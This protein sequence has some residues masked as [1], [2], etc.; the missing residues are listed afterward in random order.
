MRKFT[1]S[2][3]SVI[4]N[5]VVFIFLFNLSVGMIN[6]GG[7]F[8]SYMDPDVFP[9]LDS[10]LC[11]TAP[12]DGFGGEWKNVN[13]AG[14][15]CYL[16]GKQM[17]VSD[18]LIADANQLVDD[19][20]KLFQTQ[21]DPT[22][23]QTVANFAGSFGNWIGMAQDAFR[24]FFTS[25]TYPTQFLLSLWPCP[26]ATFAYD[27]NVLSEAKAET[28]P[29]NPDIDDYEEIVGY[30][31]YGVTF[32]YILTVIQFVSNRTVRGID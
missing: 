5:M 12:P 22:V 18:E 13:G 1:E 32:V 7:L 27:S 21:Q 11:I 17:D 8:T 16:N 6:A 29:S 31:Q 4:Y 14:Y 10:N 9:G 2:K 3:G 23:V 26:D 19:K 15:K 20:D 28:C 30:I 25:V 24:I